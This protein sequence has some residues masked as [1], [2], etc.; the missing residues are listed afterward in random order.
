MTLVSEVHRNNFDMTTTFVMK[1]RGLM[2]RLTV[3]GIEDQ[4]GPYGRYFRQPEQALKYFHDELKDVFEYVVGDSNDN[5][6]LT[7]DIAMQTSKFLKETN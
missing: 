1:R 7:I 2:G 6:V 5:V 4:F 3:T